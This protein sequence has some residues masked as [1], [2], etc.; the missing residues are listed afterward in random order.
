MRNMKLSILSAM[1]AGVAAAA[2]SGLAAEVS[3]PDEPM[4]VWF[5]RPGRTF[6]EA[7]VLGNG[8]LGAMDLGG[9]SK[10]RIVLNES[11]LWS[12]GPYVLPHS[13]HGEAQG[14][15][16]PQ[17]RDQ[18]RDGGKDVKSLS[19]EQG[20]SRT[21]ALAPRRSFLALH[22]GWHLPWIRAVPRLILFAAHAAAGWILGQRHDRAGSRPPPAGPGD[23]GAAT[24]PGGFGRGRPSGRRPGPGPPRRGGA[25][26]GS[27]ARRSCRPGP[28]RA[29]RCSG[30]PR[31]RY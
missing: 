27:A 15:G 31:S 13:L 3:S 1:V 30:P 20:R 25:G 5:D 19:G 4:S 9:V 29:R 11:S 21:C 7:T 6:H 8:R 12:G 2:G 14:Q 10:D 18:D 23:L 16:P 22:V 17:R 28:G 24:H 26:R